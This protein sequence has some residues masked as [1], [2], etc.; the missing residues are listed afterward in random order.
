MVDG[1]GM[2]VSPGV[3]QLIE[4]AKRKK[5][6]ARHNFLG[7]NHWLLALF[8]RHAPMAEAMV[9]NINSENTRKMLLARIQEGE[10]GKEVAETDVIQQASERAAQKGK[11][12]ITERDVVYVLLFMAGY[13]IQDADGTTLPITEKPSTLPESPNV[14]SQPPLSGNAETS[15]VTG[16][17]PTLDQFGR[18][19]TKEARSGNLRPLVGREDEVQLMIETLCRTTKRNPVLIGPAG[20]GKTAI[21]EGF[22]QKVISES[23]PAFLKNSR[24]IALQ[25]SILVAGAHYAGELDKRMQAILSEAKN[26]GI[27]LFIDEI[28]T[29]MGTGGMMGTSDIGSMLKP[30]LA[31]G[32][33]A[34]IA[35]TTDDEYRKFIENDT[36]LERRFQPIRV[37]ELN[38]EQTFTILQSV[39]EVLATKR[40]V[41]MEDGILRW[42]IHFGD[43]NMRNRHFP[44]KA[45]DLL[46]Q[47][48]AHSL[49]IGKNIVELS[50]AQE[51]GQRMVGMPLSLEKRLKNLEYR[52]S[53]QGILS[54]DE[55]QVIV[56]R[57]QVTMRGLDLRSG[58]PNAVLLLSGDAATNSDVLA[59]ALSKE[60]FGS[61]DRVISIDFSRFTHPSDISLLV[62]A[63]P[64]YVGYSDSLPLHRLAQIPWCILRFENMDQCVS[65][66]R[67]FI[68]QGLE[69]GMIVDGRGKPLYFSDTV[70]LITSDVRV[71]VQHGLGFKAEVEQIKSEDIYKAV[72]ESVGLEVAE[73]VDLFVPGIAKTG[74]LTKKWIEEN[75]LKDLAERYLSQGIELHWDQT[76]IDWLT[77]RQEDY[78]SERDWERWVDETLSPALIPFI[79]RSGK[80]N[81]VALNVKMDDNKVIVESIEKEK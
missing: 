76:T 72:V 78:L 35:A 23:V 56:N 2:E 21:V 54:V 33:I 13:Q 52:L 31:R 68:S 65:S 45:V 57:L 18:D 66:V 7:L 19:L 17:T 59:E 60:L 36:A 69:T 81:I 32:D 48:V 11:P 1:K 24:I 63:P 26:Q 34:V 22:A 15:N 42:L 25:P 71:S 9:K 50:D 77:K 8:E 44:D 41:K 53:Q 37:H 30:A 43:Q 29:I 80:G 73:Q 40:N 20:V 70:V 47:C 46:E 16:E 14:Q 6:E 39:R 62:G 10:L 4:H 79:P 55:I 74:G 51:V 49:A 28:H 12:Q 61:T 58:R 67:T 3:K 27:I 38:P 5:E 75:L 64:G